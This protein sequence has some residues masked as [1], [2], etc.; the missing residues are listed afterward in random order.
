MPGLDS[1]GPAIEETCMYT[2]TPDSQPI[3]DRLDDGVVLGCGFSGSGF[4]HAPA[5]G[6]ML[7]SLALGRE[8]ELP[9]GFELDR[10][11]A[12]RFT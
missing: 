3:I 6:R 11:R 2:M 12:A 4:K 10:Y 5:T 9:A 8:A 7:A 1:A